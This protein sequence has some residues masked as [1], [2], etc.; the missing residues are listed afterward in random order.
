MTLFGK[1]QQPITLSKENVLNQVMVGLWKSID[2]K[3]AQ[4]AKGKLPLSSLLYILHNY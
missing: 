3:D 1:D 4:V 2:I